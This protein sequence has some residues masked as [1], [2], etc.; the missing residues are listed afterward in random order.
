MTGRILGSRGALPLAALVAIAIAG[1]GGSDDDPPRA[2]RDTPPAGKRSVVLTIGNSVPLSG[3]LEDLGPAARKAGNLALAE[4]KAAINDTGG[5]DSVKLVTEDNATDG[6][7]T[8]RTIEAMIGKAASCVVGPW[9]SDDTV[10]VARDVAIP[11]GVALISPAATL[12]AITSLEDGGLINRT[13]APHA[14][15]GSTL[16]DAIAKDLAD[17]KD[18]TV[19]VLA[20]DDAYGRSVATTFESAWR[21]DGGT[22]GESVAYDPA[23]DDLDQVAE[24]ATDGDP[25][26]LVVVEFPDQFAGLAKSLERTGDY[27]PERTWATDLLASTE[28]AKELPE[29]LLDGLRGTVPGIPEGSEQAKAFAELFAD[30]GPGDVKREPFDAQT[31]D[32][33]ILCYLAA[34]AAGSSDGEQ[35]AVELPAVSGPPG[36]EYTWEELP[37]AV[38]A[39]RDGKEVDY[40]GVSGAIDLDAGGDPRAGAYDIYEYRGGELILVGEQAIRLP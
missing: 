17:A 33:V 23:D 32:A 40:Q 18:K 38:K 25:D 13:A 39:L 7:T 34:V 11:H 21:S 27:H 2:E 36:K 4:I 10:T 28:L 30:A 31:F 1:C 22:I 15:Q 16:A 6:P 37:A 3:E 19:N 35:L 12:D 20:R 9:A 26:A 14:Y 8:E 24:R 29:G 5:E